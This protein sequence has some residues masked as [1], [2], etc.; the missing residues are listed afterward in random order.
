MFFQALRSFFWQSGTTLAT[1]PMLE[2]GG[3]PASLSKQ[4]GLRVVGHTSRCNDAEALL[5]SRCSGV[6]FSA[7]RP[8]TFEPRR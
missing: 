6:N 5:A 7:F 3:E 1:A 2:Q 8:K 4:R